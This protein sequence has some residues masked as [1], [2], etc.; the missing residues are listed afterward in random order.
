MQ[1]NLIQAPRIF[2]RNQ[3]YPKICCFKRKISI[4]NAS[5]G[6]VVSNMLRCM[7]EHLANTANFDSTSKN[8]CPKR[9][10]SKIMLL[11]A[12][13][14][15]LGRSGGRGCCERVALYLRTLRKHCQLCFEANKYSSKADNPKKCFASSRKSCFPGG[16]GYCEHVVSYVRTLRKHDQTNK[17]HHDNAQHN[18]RATTD[19]ARDNARTT[20]NKA[21]AS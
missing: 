16:R 17:Y 21:R 15:D 1:P 7:C 18:A 9:V 12:E 3:S 2:V 14:L 10:I 13:N 8:L 11:Q 5:A 19:S 20:P 6:T 4:W